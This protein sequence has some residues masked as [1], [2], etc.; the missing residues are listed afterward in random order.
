[1]SVLF[2]PVLS[3]KF[4]EYELVGIIEYP[5][6]VHLIQT[7]IQ[8]YVSD[9]LIKGKY[10]LNLRAHMTSP[11]RIPMEQPGVTAARFIK[12]HWHVPF[13]N[14]GFQ[15]ASRIGVVRVGFVRIVRAHVP[16][17]FNKLRDRSCPTA[18]T[19]NT[20]NSDPGLAIRGYHNGYPQADFPYINTI[21]W[22]N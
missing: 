13:H 4:I 1:M 18:L 19:L 8:N 7:S 2:F 9:Y 20:V 5:A 14:S 21:E 10:F 15:R 6:S 16:L 3:G 22:P 12:C 11:K 17:R